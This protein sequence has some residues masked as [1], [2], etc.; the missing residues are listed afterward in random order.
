MFE[1]QL[2]KC[3]VKFNNLQADNK[4]L[5]SQIDVMRKEQKNQTRVNRGY[6]HELKVTNEKAKKLNTTSF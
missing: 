4:T 6:N 1:N 2:D 3:L 5:R